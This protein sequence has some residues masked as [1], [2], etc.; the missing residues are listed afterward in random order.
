MVNINES[1]MR[2]TPWVNNGSTPL[3]AMPG[4]SFGAIQKKAIQTNDCLLFEVE[5][6]S[7]LLSVIENQASNFFVL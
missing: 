4:V 2:P 3:T 6:L 7:G 5:V 1:I